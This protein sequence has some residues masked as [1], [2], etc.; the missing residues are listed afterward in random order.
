MP[1]SKEQ[2]RKIVDENIWVLKNLT[3]TNDWRTTVRIIDDGSCEFSARVEPDGNYRT[4][5]ITIDA[6]QQDDEACVLKDLRHELLHL[7]HAPMLLY[8]ESM[9]DACNYTEPQRALSRRLS[10]FAFEQLVGNIEMMLDTGVPWEKA[11]RE[12][13]S[14]AKPAKTRSKK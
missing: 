5:L 4:A 11:Q 8:M 7:L 13:E 3:Q 6:A 2:V 14:K 1:L 9:A 12:K 10:H